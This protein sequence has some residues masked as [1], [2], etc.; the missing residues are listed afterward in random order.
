MLLVPSYL[1]KLLLL[2]NQ[3][4]YDCILDP[5]I[6]KMFLSIPQIYC[7]RE[8]QVHWTQ[9]ISH[10]LKK[11][12]LRIRS[13]IL[14]RERKGDRDRNW[15]GRETSIGCHPP[16]GAPT[17]VR[18]CNPGLCPDRELNSHLLAYWTMLQPPRP[19][20]RAV[21]YFYNLVHRKAFCTWMKLDKY[22]WN[23]V[24]VSYLPSRDFVKP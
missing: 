23:L 2:I 22:S 1:F 13:L 11:P 5:S 17:R 12:C 16:I 6:W 18:T 3:Y 4:C 8:I 14:E 20:A 15:H 21:S 9:E 24:C 19:L 10:F 7:N